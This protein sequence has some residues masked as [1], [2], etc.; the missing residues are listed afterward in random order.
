MNSNRRQIG[1]FFTYF[2]ASA[3]NHS[4]LTVHLLP[5]NEMMRFVG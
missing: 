2:E 3:V 1:S 4:K 5:E